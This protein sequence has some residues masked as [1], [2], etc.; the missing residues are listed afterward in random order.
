MIP[1]NNTSKYHRT[2]AAFGKMMSPTVAAHNLVFLSN[3]RDRFVEKACF[4]GR[5]SENNLSYAF[6]QFHTCYGHQHSVAS[7]TNVDET[8]IVQRSS[9][10]QRQWRQRRETLGTRLWLMLLLVFST[11]WSVD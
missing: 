4:E 9:I 8:T 3:T 7:Q 2:V 1:I 5:K 6:T 10:V 11:T